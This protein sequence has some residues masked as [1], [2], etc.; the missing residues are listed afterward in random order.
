M[1]EPNN[2]E[3]SKFKY[4]IPYLIINAYRVELTNYQSDFENKDYLWEAEIHYSQGKI[5]AKVFTPKI[6]VRVIPYYY[7]A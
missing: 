3:S 5:K 2:W 4:H 7:K 1:K 6:T